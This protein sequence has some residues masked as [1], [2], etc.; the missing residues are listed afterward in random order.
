M[1]VVK[2]KIVQNFVTM[3]I[4]IMPRRRILKWLAALPRHMSG[5]GCIKSKAKIVTEIFSVLQIELDAISW[6]QE[7]YKLSHGNAKISNS[8]GI[9]IE[10]LFS[11]FPASNTLIFS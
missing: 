10:N 4:A 3:S 8:E 11:L 2:K 6:L 9:T 1:V 5:L 7:K